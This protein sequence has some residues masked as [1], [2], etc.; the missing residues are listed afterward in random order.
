MP[1]ILSTLKYSAE[2]EWIDESSPVKVGVTEF[3]TEQLGDIVF[4]DLPQVGDEVTAGEV[5]GELESTKSVSDLYSPV[6]GTVAAI[7]EEVVDDP[8]LVNQDPYGKGWL[9]SVEVTENGPLLD[10]QAYAEEF[11]VEVT[12]G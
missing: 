8:E 2:H 10:A 1:A 12:E 9:F 3:A 5:C 6:S 4:V 7:N 11:D